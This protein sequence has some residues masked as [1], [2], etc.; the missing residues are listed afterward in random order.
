MSPAKI[1]FAIIGYGH[2]G[3][4]HAGFIRAN[5]A[6]EL[7]AVCDSR[8]AGELPSGI[9]S[10]VAFYDDEDDLLTQD[11]DVLCIATPNGL[12]GH[13]ALKALEKGFHV[14]IEKPMAL[15]ATS[16]AAI[17]RRAEEYNRHV[18]TVMQNRYS[19]PSVWLK[20]LLNRQAL[21]KIFLVTINCFW[22]R[23]EHYYR[24]DAWRGTPDLD[25]GT[26]FTQFSHF[27]DSLLWLFGDIG[28]IDARFANFSHAETIGFEDSGIVTF[29][30]AQGGMGC[31]NYT[32]SVRNANL[33]SSLTIIA[34]KGT[35]KISGQYMDEV[36]VCDIAGEP[37]PSLAPSL[38]SSLP[39]SF[40][41]PSVN[42]AFIFENIVS[43][44]RN[45][46]P[47]D[48]DPYEAYKVVETIERIYAL[49]K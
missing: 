49:K 16:C 11:F 20:E 30:F 28:D 39:A 36:A 35:V 4:R 15:T 10:G 32:T 17:M 38:A 24:K 1:K 2:I 48:I 22:N 19:P 44:L 13:H 7:T 21:G 42:H 8:P 18:F 46:Q 34:E 14:L 33:E 26:L 25:G 45:G 43:V 3:S 37:A 31:L 27:I 6:C 5:P 40:S 23:D 41:R 29:R 12:H 47:P 9:P